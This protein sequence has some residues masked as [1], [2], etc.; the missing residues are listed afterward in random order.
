MNPQDHPSQTSS[1][2]GQKRS[3]GRAMSSER[4][5]SRCRCRVAPVSDR[6]ILGK[7]EAEV[8]AGS[9]QAHSTDVEI[10]L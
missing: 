1:E 5:T 7:P 2:K 4:P 8:V 10:S 6:R 3:A 9:G